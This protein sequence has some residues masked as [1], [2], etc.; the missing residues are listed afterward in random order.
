MRIVTGVLAGLL[1]VA[2]TACEPKPPKPKTD[3][4]QSSASFSRAQ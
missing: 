4:A 3:A 2:L 1:L